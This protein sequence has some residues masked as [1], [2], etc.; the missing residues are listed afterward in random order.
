MPDPLTFDAADDLISA[1]RRGR[2]K[3]PS[4]DAAFFSSTIGPLIELTH[5][6]GPTLARSG[7]F[8]AG[9]LQAFATAIVEGSGAWANTERTAGLLRCIA[10]PSDNDL[11]VRTSFLQAAS[12]A[13]KSVGFPNEAALRFAAALREMDS[14]VLEH[15]CAPQTG[16][17]AY[18]AT[19]DHFEFVVA[20]SG[21]GVL[22]TLSQAPEYRG[23]TDHGEALDLALRDGVSRYGQAAHR[24]MGFSDLF[25]GLATINAD[26]RFRSGDHA[27]TIAGPSPDLKQRQL[28]QKPQL[29]GFLISVRCSAP[30][31]RA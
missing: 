11:L 15:S 8:R 14:N 10:N 23:L 22:A 17:L 12:R 19:A 29:Q 27:L 4:A 3:T 5:S 26:L 6:C 31:R 16:L 24:G 9:A 7:W 20:D 18:Q 25:R 2:L 1:F 28:A 21:V 30:G 13:A